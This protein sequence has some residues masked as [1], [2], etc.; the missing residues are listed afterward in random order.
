MTRCHGVSS[1]VKEQRNKKTIQ[2]Q[3]AASC[4][5]KLTVLFQRQ[6]LSELEKPGIGEKAT[7]HLSSWSSQSSHG[8]V[9]PEA[10][11]TVFP[12]PSCVSGSWA[13]AGPRSYCVPDTQKA[14]KQQLLSERMN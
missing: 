8:H 6:R 2:R 11:G 1:V 14:L 3:H 9:R 7:G 5:G 10:N 13:I 4:P 12:G